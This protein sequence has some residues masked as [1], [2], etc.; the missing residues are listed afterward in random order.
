MECIPRE[1]CVVN[2]ETY[3]MN[4]RFLFAIAVACISVIVMVSSAVRETKK[5]VVSVE[6]LRTEGVDRERIRLG[7][8]VTE[9]EIQV[10]T[11]PE[12]EV[13]FSVRDPGGQSQAIVPVLYRGALPDT[14]QA[15]RDVILEGAYKN[16]E[17]VASSLMTQ[18]PSK[19]EPPNPNDAAK[20]EGYAQNTVQY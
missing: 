19:Y 1:K 4:T 17:F 11:R 5:A 7:A 6:E 20:A 13:R 10:R 2:A 15:G 12:R 16:A 14:L 9:G 18:C 3:F 8:R